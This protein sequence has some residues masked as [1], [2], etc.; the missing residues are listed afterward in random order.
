MK[1]TVTRFEQNLYDWNFWTDDVVAKFAAWLKEN[2]ETMADKKSKAFQN[3][4]MLGFAYQYNR[5]LFNAIDE[6]GFRV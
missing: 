1:H 4:L 6:R 5:R 3:A 2:G